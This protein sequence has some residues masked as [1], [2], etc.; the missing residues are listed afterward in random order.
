MTNPQP[1]YPP[2]HYPAPTQ[3]VARPAYVQAQPRQLTPWERDEVLTR[4]IHQQA[5]QGWRVTQKDGPSATMWG[6]A[7]WMPVWAHL[8][9][10]VLTLSVWALPWALMNRSKRCRQVHVDAWGRVQAV[11]VPLRYY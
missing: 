3:Q 11:N 6:P 1:M 4:Y 8:A 10:V 9:L 5:G 2:Q 7:M